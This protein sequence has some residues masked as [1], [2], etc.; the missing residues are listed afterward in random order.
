MDYKDF[1]LG[2]IYFI[3]I[4]FIAYSIRNKVVKDKSIRGYFI[5]ALT[6][7]L[8]GAITLGIIYKFYYNGGD[9]LNYFIYGSQII[10]DA[11][12]ENP[13]AGLYM[14]FGPTCDY[15]NEYSQYLT[16][17]LYFCDPSSYF[18]IRVAGFLSL[19]TFNTYVAIAMFFALISFIGVWT[20]FTTLTTIYPQLK[21]QL[22]MAC[23]L[24]PSVIFWGSGLM[25]DSLTFG[26]L[27]LFFSS[28]YKIFIA[29]KRTKGTILLFFL[30]FLIIKTVKIYIILC[31]IPA[32][33][34]WLFM[35]YNEKIKS[36]TTR[37][38]LRPVMVM[39]GCVFGYFAAD[40]VSKEDEKYSMTKLAQTAESTAYWLSYVSKVEKGSGYSL[41][42]IEFTPWGMAKKIPA[43]INVTLFRPYLWEARNI[44]MILSALESLFFLYVTMMTIYKA[45]LKRTY[46]SISQHPVVAASLVFSLTFAFAVG[47]STANFGTLVRYKIPMMPFYLISI[48][49]INH[50][51]AKRKKSEIINLYRPMQVK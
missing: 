24:L 25:K 8:F 20:M 23:F 3:L 22:V 40:F 34:L 11:F 51:T 50:Y 30:S 19:F 9:T 15:D 13:S 35:V 33:A 28:F 49:V 18:V 7:K 32:A 43:A 14:I 2:P 10:W 47:L 4:Y 1:F 44:V 48:I 42:E 37:L 12:L 46:Q 29:N 38:L 26:C 41:G 21:K 36:R 45:G 17:V 5:P 6:L 31:F 27:G 16:K 39:I